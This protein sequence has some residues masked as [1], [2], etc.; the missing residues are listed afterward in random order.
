MTSTQAVTAPAEPAAPT[1][2]RPTRTSPVPAPPVAT[3]AKRRRPALIGLG[4]ALV[5]LC[6]LFGWWFTSRGAQTQTVLVAAADIEAGKPVTI[7]QLSTTEIAGGS[8]TETMPS[9]QLQNTPGLLATSNIPEGTVLSPAMFVNKVTPDGGMSIVG[10]SVKPSQMPALGLRPGDTVSVV[11][12]HSPQSGGQSGQPGEDTALTTGK[13]W[14]ATVASVGEP[15]DDGARTIDVTLN[16]DSAREL[17]A[18][19]GSG[20]LAIALDPSAR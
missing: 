15:G 19:G 13:T 14:R 12:A 18:A 20:R 5:V 11:I 7:K 1:A 4:V 2:T 10:V 9:E 17:I 16:S 3:A 8:G 6:G